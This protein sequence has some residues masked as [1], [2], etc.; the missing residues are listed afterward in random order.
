M[1][2]PLKS[3]KTYDLQHILR[4]EKVLPTMSTYSKQL[5]DSFHKIQHIY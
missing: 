2:S 3:D 5:P 4:T 1:K